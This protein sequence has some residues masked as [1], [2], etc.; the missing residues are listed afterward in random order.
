MTGLD[1]LTGLIIGL[2]IGWWACNRCWTKRAR[3]TA[4]ELVAHIAE[5]DRLHA[6]MCDKLKELERL[7]DRQ[8]GA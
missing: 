2:P 5:A 3:Q 4:C 7:E 1:F 6:E 8:T